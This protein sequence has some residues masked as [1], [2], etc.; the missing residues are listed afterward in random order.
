LSH[1][2]GLA[3]QFSDVSS[4]S[5]SPPKQKAMIWVLASVSLSNLGQ[6]LE[7]RLNICAVTREFMK[8]L[9]V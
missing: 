8:K 6:I 4:T 1:C 3:L 7:E 9:H 2:H 5:L